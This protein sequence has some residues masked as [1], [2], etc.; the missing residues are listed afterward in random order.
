MSGIFDEVVR[1][2]S[3]LS[4]AQRNRYEAVFEVC[5]IDQV[6]AESDRAET[7]GGTDRFAQVRCHYCQKRGHISRYCKKKNTDKLATGKEKGAIEGPKVRSQNE[8]ME[9][10]P[11]RG[12]RWQEEDGM[13]MRRDPVARGVVQCAC[14]ADTEV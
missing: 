8:T 11:E 4:T 3:N 7:L 10:W 5:E 6:Q 9:P 12:T 2:V 1:R 13:W 14:R